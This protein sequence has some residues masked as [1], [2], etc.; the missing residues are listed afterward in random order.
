MC[1]RSR[2]SILLAFLN[3][4]DVVFLVSTREDVQERQEWANDVMSSS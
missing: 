1:A 2:R 4:L 3:V